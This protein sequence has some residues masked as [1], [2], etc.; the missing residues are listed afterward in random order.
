[1]KTILTVAVVLTC[2]AITLAA[3]P[4][5]Y[6]KTQTDQ[7]ASSCLGEIKTADDWNAHK[8]Q[9]RQQLAEMLGLWPMPEKTELHATITGRIDQGDFVV[10]NL[11]YQSMP[12]LYVTANLYLPKKIEARL[13]AIV[14]VCGHSQ[15]KK[16]NVSYGNKTAYQHHGAWFAKNGYVCIVLDTLQLGEIEGIHHGL[17]REKMWWWMSRGYT[18]AGVEA[19]NSIRAIDY[20]VSRPEVDPTKIGITGRSGGGAY[21]WWT[22]A[23]DDRIACAVPVAGI[24]DMHNH[25]VDGTIEGHCD[26]MFMTNTYRW[27]FAQ[28]AV[29]VAPRPLLISNSD[30]DTI[31][32]LDGV[33]RLH[34]QVARIY[35]LNKAEKNLGL[36]ITEGPHKDTQELQ[37]PAFKWFNRF[38]KNDLG[39]IQMLMES[40][41]F[42]PEQLRVF[43]PGEE[44][45]DSINLKIAESF[46]PIAKPQVPQT[47]ETW[48]KTRDRMMTGLKQK[49]FAGWPKETIDLDVKEIAKSEKDGWRMRVLEF[50][51]GP[52]VRP[53]IYLVDPLAGARASRINLYVLGENE[54]KGFVGNMSGL[55]GDVL[56]GELGQQERG[57][58]P[59]SGAYLTVRGVG[60]SSWGVDEKKRT[61]ILRRYWL[62][63]QTLD[64]MRVWDVRRAI[65]AM[66]SIDP[67]R[68]LRLTGSGEIGAVALYASLFEPGI[69]EIALQTPPASHVVGPQ[70]LNVLKLMDVPAAAAMAAE[71]CKVRIVSSDADAWNYPK[72]V[73]EKMRWKTFEVADK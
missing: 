8:E 66:K 65:A 41:F 44:P 54:W 12:H 11:H 63:G 49:V 1:M 19:W 25:I 46:I 60:S 16:A 47:K 33:E 7:I 72:E 59:V 24:T 70:L 21:S 52:N 18:P 64:G 67:S 36:L 37:L 39:P 27:D 5:E 9:Y 26:C 42:E 3:T 57:D 13:P 17:Y 69:P 61:Q 50:A 40:K 34:A 4:D 29:L 6:F 22:A 73:A 45:K 20:L 14:Y 23:L 2:C 35:K 71:R 68:E 30:K 55:F 32:P 38:L 31:F 28:V 51:S 58:G 53:R 15:V 62:V 48:E 43:K 10:E 56:G